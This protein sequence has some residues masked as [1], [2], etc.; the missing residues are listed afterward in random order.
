ML[1]AKCCES[2]GNFLLA[3]ECYND[4]LQVTEG[5]NDNQ[6]IAFVLQHMGEIQMSKLDDYAEAQNYS[7]MH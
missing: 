6:N 5:L 2:L 3:I 4:C 7:L 1:K